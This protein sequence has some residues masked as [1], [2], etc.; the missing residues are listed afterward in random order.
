MKKFMALLSFLLVGALLLAPIT[1]TLAEAWGTGSSGG[2]AGAPSGVT[3]GI[4]EVPAET[5]ALL[6]AE[7][8]LTF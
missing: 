8:A 4:L 7:L 6:S 1:A 2:G 5:R 3:I